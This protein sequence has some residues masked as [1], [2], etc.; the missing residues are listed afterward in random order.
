M[1]KMP[2]SYTRQGMTKAV[3]SEMDGFGNKTYMK[4]NLI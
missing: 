3:S 4:K 2:H 1:I